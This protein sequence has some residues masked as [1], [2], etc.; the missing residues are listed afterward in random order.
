MS[1][2]FQ[3]K[4]TDEPTPIRGVPNLSAMETDPEAMM[5][6][7]EQQLSDTPDAESNNNNANPLAK[8]KDLAKNL[9][10]IDEAMSFNQLI[11]QVKSMEYDVVVFDT[12]PTGH[13]LR[14][15]SLPQTLESGLGGLMDQVGFLVLSFKSD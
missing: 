12:A 11:A 8:L 9:P 6:K 1:D 7:M 5:N 4:I 15:L 10:G 14:L 3:Q 2:A 13:T